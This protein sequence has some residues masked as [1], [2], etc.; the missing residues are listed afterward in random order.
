MLLV[1][2]KVGPSSACARPVQDWPMQKTV[3]TKGSK[4]DYADF[5]CPQGLFFEHG[6][7][8]SYGWLAQCVESWRLAQIAR[9]A[10][11]YASFD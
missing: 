9:I 7:L 10:K 4:A 3:M 2:T 11:R 1:M 8:G 6:Y 5:A